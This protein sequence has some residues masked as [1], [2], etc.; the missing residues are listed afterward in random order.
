MYRVQDHPVLGPGEKKKEVTIY[1][2][3][4]PLPAFEGESIAAALT[5]SGV[6]M[7]RRTSRL[8]APRKMFCGIGQCTDCMMQV[9]GIPNTRTCVTRVRE[10]MVVETQYETGEFHG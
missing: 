1:F 3:G 5:A 8:Q 9:D 10:G 6:R 2:D 7:F 4:K